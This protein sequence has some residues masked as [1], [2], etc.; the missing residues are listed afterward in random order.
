MYKNVSEGVV[1]VKYD[2][3]L[4]LSFIKR[5]RI[6][7]GLTHQQLAEGLSFKNASTYFK[8][9]NGS[10]AFKADHLP[11]LSRILKCDIDEL[12]SSRE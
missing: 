4:N 5:R 6:S 2:A 7:L 8:Y 12:F 9:E 10:Y 3:T 11:K 1:I